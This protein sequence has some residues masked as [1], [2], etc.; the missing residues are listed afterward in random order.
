[1][2][3]L[4]IIPTYNERE[5]VGQIIPKILGLDVSLEILVV[6]DNSPDGTWRAVQALQ[7]NNNRLHLVV[8]E[9]KKGLGKAYVQGFR[10]AVDHRFEFICQMD[11]DFSHRPRDLKNILDL[12]GG[13]WDVVIGSRW[14]TDG[15]AINWNWIRKSIS[16]WGSF[17]SRHILGYSIRDWTGGFN[18]WR[19]HVL[20]AIGLDSIDSEGYSFQIE[21]KYRALKR[22]F[23]VKEFPIQFEERRAGQSKMSMKIVLEALH[24]VWRIRF[25]K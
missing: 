12:R 19:R 3:T 13:Q 7:E 14:V 11:A 17:Y 23:T 10:W 15:G 6:D 16:R 9:G 21:M 8:R 4:V 20:R 25:A 5:N 24:R 22:G 18:L 1:M 2:K